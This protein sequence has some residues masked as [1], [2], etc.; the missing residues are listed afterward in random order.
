MGGYRGIARSVK[1]FLGK[2]EDLNSISGPTWKSQSWWHTLK[3]LRLG[4]KRVMDPWRL[5]SQQAKAN[6]QTPGHGETPHHNLMKQGIRL[7]RFNTWDYLPVSMHLCTCTHEHMLEHIH[8][9]KCPFLSQLSYA[10]KYADDTET[11][12][13][14]PPRVQ[15]LALELH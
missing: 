2:H 5:A 14:V 4:R 13:S 8:M 15:I 10:C 3:I 7:L 1:W 6:W 9:K 12:I 11:G